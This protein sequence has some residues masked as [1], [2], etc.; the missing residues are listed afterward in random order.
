MASG[1]FQDSWTRRLVEVLWA[2]FVRQPN[3]W[4][5]SFTLTIPG[6]R[7]DRD[8]ELP[9]LVNFAFKD[10]DKFI[11][12]MHA[13]LDK[14]S[15]A[16]TLTP[17]SGRALGAVL[18]FGMACMLESM[19][20]Q[21]VPI[22]EYGE[23]MSRFLLESARLE[24][25]WAE[26]R[27]D[28]P[29]LLEY[30]PL[31]MLEDAIYLYCQSTPTACWIH[32]LWG[33]WQIDRQAWGAAEQFIKVG[34]DGSPRDP[35]YHE[36]WWYYFEARVF[37]EFSAKHWSDVERLLELASKWALPGDRW[38]IDWVRCTLAVKRKDS[39]IEELF[40][41]WIADGTERLVANWLMEWAC[42]QAK[43]PA[44]SKATY[45]K[46][47]EAA[48]RT[49]TPQAA[50]QLVNRMA[51]RV[52]LTYSGAVTHRKELCSYLFYCF[53]ANKS[54]S[55]LEIHQAALGLWC[56]SD[57]NRFQVITFLNGFSKSEGHIPGLLLLGSVVSFDD[58]AHLMREALIC[59]DADPELALPTS[60]VVACK[61]DPRVG[62]GTNSLEK[63]FERQCK[64]MIRQAKGLN[65]QNSRE[66]HEFA[67]LQHARL[68]AYR[69]RTKFSALKELQRVALAMDFVS[70]RMD[71]L[72]HQ[73]YEDA[74]E[75]DGT[76]EDDQ[77]D[78]EFE[79]DFD[80]GE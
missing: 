10:I 35:V 39:N 25:N 32:F 41:K 30:A 21:S 55:R 72:I 73:A 40:E 20:E 59:S 6:P 80:D 42:V 66:L 78:D 5:G 23:L 45:K 49:N 18:L 26:V 77:Y 64:K 75:M 11:D 53:Q 56:V 70:E 4:A 69:E 14:A 47:R 46:E 27:G 52:T 24:P 17:R 28:I 79:L 50:L 29:R 48:L 31:P 54:W 51:Q 19:V 63:N 58:G 67:L 8:W 22:E 60:I 43:L 44:A 76:Y 3:K 36:L 1:A 33:K 65:G 62:D 2:R 38:R 16:G 68:A 15:S 61:T 9:K 71:T 37:A 74:E 57:Q 12:S 13:F 7:W 34:L